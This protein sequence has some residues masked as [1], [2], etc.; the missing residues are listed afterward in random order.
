MAFGGRACSMTTL[1]CGATMQ[2]PANGLLRI[3]LPRTPV[4]KGE[5]YPR[6][7]MENC[8]YRMNSLITAAVS[9]GTSSVGNWLTPSN[10]CTEYQ[11]F[12]RANDSCAERYLGARGWAYTW[13]TDTGGLN[14]LNT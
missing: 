12:S 9:S 10:R 2:D 6:L 13:S 4:N 7:R 8:A 14:R 5:L 3:T 1:N 11:G